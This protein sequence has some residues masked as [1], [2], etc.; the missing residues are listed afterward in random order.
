[1]AA[2]EWPKPRQG[3]RRDLGERGPAPPAGPARRPKDSTCDHI[4]LGSVA[5]DHSMAWVEIRPPPAT[6]VVREVVSP[7]NLIHFTSLATYPSLHY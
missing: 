5:M 3:G 1:M 2:A 7:P 4:R 6:A